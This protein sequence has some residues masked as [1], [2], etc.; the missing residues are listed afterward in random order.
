MRLLQYG[1]FLG[2]PETLAA[3]RVRR[4]GPAAP[5]EAAARAQERELIGELTGSPY[6]AVRAL[7]RGVGS[8]LGPLR[9]RRR[10]AL[11]RAARRHARR[12]ERLA[13]S[14]ADG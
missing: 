2:L 14:A 13:R 8:V 11:H 7:D 1:E 12:D 4:D 5:A 10:S 9:R 6:F 3:V